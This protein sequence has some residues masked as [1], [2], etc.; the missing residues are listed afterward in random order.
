MQFEV[1][2]VE[3]PGKDYQNSELFLWNLDPVLQN[4]GPDL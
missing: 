1:F 3:R 4:L 2:F